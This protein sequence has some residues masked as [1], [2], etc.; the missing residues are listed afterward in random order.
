MRKVQEIEDLL[1]P[2]AAREKIEIVDVQYS[3][4]A[5][6]WVARIFIDKDSGVTISDC[7]NIS[8]I[9]GAF[10]DESDILKDSHVLEISSPGFKRVL[11]SE[12]SFRRFIGSKTRIR[13]F[14]PIN[15]QRNFLG[16]LLNFDDG[17]IKINDVTNGV[18]EIEFS[19]IRKANIEA[20]I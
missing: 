15:N 9:F 1:A 6:D 19:D 12:K 3:K 8:C 2:V 17:R 20:D 5:G 14:K 16:T 4:K 18:V 11:K 7:E 13:T 10:L